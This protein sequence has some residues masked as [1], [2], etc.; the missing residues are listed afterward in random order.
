MA[1]RWPEKEQVAS[2]IY[3]WLRDSRI[4]QQRVAELVGL[5]SDQF[6]QGYKNTARA[7]KTDPNVAI[8]IVRIFTGRLAQKHASAA[9][10]LKFLI[11]THLPLDRFPEV[12]SLFPPADW[13]QA[14]RD[15]FPNQQWVR[16]AQL[17]L[18]APEGRADA[19]TSP[20]IDTPYLLISLT[21][22]PDNTWSRIYLVEQ[23][24]IL[25]R[26][27]AHEPGPGYVKLN[28]PHVSREHAQIMREPGG[29][30]LKN[31]NAKYG[32]G[33]Y[34]KSLEP[35][36][37]HTLRHGDIFRIPDHEDH[38]RIMFLL[39][40]KQTLVLPFH[41]EYSTRN[42]RVFERTL[43]LS[44]IEYNLIVYLY[45][46]R[47]RVC[48]YEEL[49]GNLWPDD[50]GIPSDRWATLDTLLTNVRRNI[51]EASGGFTFMQT[52]GEIGVRLVV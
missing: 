27:A 19:S 29:Y 20:P 41:V 16:P 32:I 24:T 3:K 22:D 33:L 47:D 11:L 50:S 30:L 25:G 18:G 1:K 49:M 10:A 48:S 15:L 14:M 21:T 4:D 45:S 6:Y 9:D 51:S 12:Q 5:T 13:Q 17:A 28:Q 8:E 52:T 31:R 34:E 23:S 42:V 46:H 38:Y 26:L 40:D 44:P 36:E 43:A 35:G 2:L 7:V 37:V 39:S